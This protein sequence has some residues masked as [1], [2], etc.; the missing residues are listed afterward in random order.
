MAI[1][2]Y[3]GKSDTFVDAITRFAETYANQAEA[4]YAV[5][6]EAIDSGRLSSEAPEDSP[7]SS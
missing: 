7:V 4:D 5:F 3:L 6:R 2:E 1:A